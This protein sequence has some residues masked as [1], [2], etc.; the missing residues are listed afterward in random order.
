MP[1]QVHILPESQ[2]YRS[3]QENRDICLKI[4]SEGTLLM[5]LSMRLNIYCRTTPGIKMF[6]FDD[7][8]FT[9]DKDWL[10]E[11]SQRYKEVTDISFVCNA[12]ATD[13]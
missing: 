9:F 13:I 1:I 11:F 6:I 2:D 8:I 5:R 4:T 7:D 10:K 12:H 3:L